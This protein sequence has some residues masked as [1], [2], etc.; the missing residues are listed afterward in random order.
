MNRYLSLFLLLSL[1]T[2][3]QGSEPD[4]GASEEIQQLPFNR[5]SLENLESFQRPGINWQIVGS[6]K[7]D[8]Q[9]DHSI[10]VEEG[11]GVLANLP[12]GSE[13]T[14]L[15]TNLE[16]GDIELK[17]E[18]LVPK[19][20]NSG[21]YFQNRYELQIL[22]SWR[23]ENPQYSDIGGIYE[24]WDETLP[25]G[26][27]GYDGH[28]PIVNAG[29]APG[30]W[31]EYH[32][33][34]RAP[35]FDQSGNK[36]RNARFEFVRLN[37]QLVQEEVEL[38]G[39]TRGAVSEVEVPHAPILIQGDHGPVA[40]RNFRYKTYEQTDSLRLS[41]LAYT[42][43]DFNGVRLPDFDHLT[44]TLAEGVTESFDVTGISPKNEYYAA[45]FSGELEVPVTGEYL[46]Q[47]RI[48]NAGN[49]YIDGELVIPNDGEIDYH[50]IGNILHLE[51]G[52]HQIDMSYFQRTWSRDLWLYYEGP[53]MERRPLGSDAPAE[54]YS[55]NNPLVLTPES[56]EP[57]LIGG[58]TN[59]GEEKRTH[60]LSIGTAE[61]MHYSYDLYNA[62][63]L[64]FWRGPFADVTQMWRGRGEEQLLVPLNASVED[65]SLF[66]L[67]RSE[68]NSISYFDNL[69]NRLREQEY[70][71][72]E[73]GLPLFR[74]HIDGIQIDDEIFPDETGQFLVR[75]LRYQADEVR[76][77]FMAVLAAGTELDQI[78]SEL[79]R[80][81]GN[82][83]V[84]LPANLA[85]DI[86]IRESGDL[87]TL[88]LPIFQNSNR[89]DIRYELIW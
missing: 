51:S 12:T 28:A 85:S 69:P 61:G 55:V 38:A 23:T 39:P 9:V 8:F 43:Y 59:Y 76:P 89:S 56:G 22:D 62:K 54:G 34:F 84:R 80:V 31:Q 53:G 86:S 77:D 58:F 3:C 70:H 45:W 83:Y 19:G 42:V 48:S 81:N 63:L 5:V 60:T 66:A 29:L 17:I 79:Y 15:V 71:I 16:H 68:G 10:E 4:S 24:R 67:A 37:G 2:A 88:T 47:T 50:L 41:Q 75:H 82:F 27:R 21:I 87:Q 14:N 33:L 25:E 44:D 32:V 11:S 1:V 30:L 57:Q 52:T 74:N 72:Q 73:S 26:E 64:K 35:R 20:S 18:F 49:L 78:S 13:D 36:V 6:V 46:F 7:S 65:R 40:F